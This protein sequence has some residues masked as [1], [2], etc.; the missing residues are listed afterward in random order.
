MLK[1]TD[2]SLSNA[3]LWLDSA[4][5]TLAVERAGLDQL[6]AALDADL[7]EAFVAA[8]EAIS[9]A[10]GRI[11]LSGVGKSGH[12]AR[13]IAA[14]LASTGTPAMF[15][16]ATEASHGDLGMITP[17]DVIVVLSNSGETVEL[18]DLLVYSRRFAVTVIAMTTGKRSTLAKT[19]DIVLVLPRAEEACPIGLAPT[20]STTLQLAIGDAL[21]IALLEARGFTASDFQRYHPGGRL[22]AALTHISEI[23]HTGDELPLAPAG[24]DM[25][26]ALI[27]MTTKRFGCLG[28]VDAAGRLI[29]IITDGDLRRHMG[30]DLL[31]RS[32]GDIMTPDPKVVAPDTLASTAIEM[33]N[34]KQITSLF[35]TDG[36]RPVGIVHIHDLLRIGVR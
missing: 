30:G 4:R 33:L 34:A 12:I 16:H 23:M 6:V 31:T 13:K 25:Q 14:T 21:A 26:T 5:H 10:A 24:L 29:G 9:Q 8:V 11:I 3:S 35:V 27:T 15:V 28:I 19:A 20:T 32:A 18:R 2:P 1:L 36:T 17:D 7:G 22:G